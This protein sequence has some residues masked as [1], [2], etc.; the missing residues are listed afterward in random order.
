V[1]YAYLVAG[2][3]YWGIASLSASEYIQTTI[4]QP[5]SVVYLPEKPG[6][7]DYRPDRWVRHNGVP[8]LGGVVWLIFGLLSL[9]TVAF[10]H[11]TQGLA[12]ERAALRSARPAQALTL[13]VR[14]T[15]TSPIV[16]SVIL[17]G[18]MIMGLALQLQ[19]L[20][21]VIGG[22]PV[23]VTSNLSGTVETG[24]ASPAGLVALTLFPIIFWG[25]ALAFLIYAK[26]YSVTTSPEGIE[27]HKLGGKVYRWR[28][29]QIRTA[30]R[31]YA[32]G[33]NQYV[34]GN[35]SEKVW[36]TTVDDNES[37]SS[38]IEGRLGS[39]IR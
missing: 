27:I 18:F 19:M 12:A 2:Q 25:P 33:V 34:L 21:M 1:A 14:R 36:V 35:G 24:A 29:E 15:Y 8:N 9:S 11:Y 31:R 16:V 3:R 4:G 5:L 6:L 23:A 13:P 28:W 22:K 38:E 37:L 10:V 26:S 39:L 20:W 7:S 30:E 17:F 32:R